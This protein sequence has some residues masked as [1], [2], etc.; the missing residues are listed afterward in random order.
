[1]IRDYWGIS[2]NRLADELDAIKEKCDPELYLAMT[3]LKAIGNIGAHPERDISLIVEIDPGEAETLIEL[4][5]LLDQ[6]WYVARE[7]R[8][9]RVSKVH[10]LALQKKIQQKAGAAPAIPANGSATPTG[11]V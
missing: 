9:Q 1:M 11:E 3:G 4:I 7:R 10:E 2:R 8:K 6:E 5:L